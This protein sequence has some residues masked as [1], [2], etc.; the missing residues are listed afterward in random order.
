[1]S[2]ESSQQGNT[3]NRHLNLEGHNNLFWRPW[4]LIPTTEYYLDKT[5]K[6]IMS[7]LLDN[8]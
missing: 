1:M 2:Y 5:Q 7:K 6:V 8:C 4:L 3:L